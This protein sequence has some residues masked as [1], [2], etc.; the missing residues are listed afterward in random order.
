M[1]ENL[2]YVVIDSEN[3]LRGHIAHPDRP[4]VINVK[5]KGEVGLQAARWMCSLDV[6]SDLFWSSDAMAV[7]HPRE[8]DLATDPSDGGAP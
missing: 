6:T 1:A 4:G 5:W 8:I 7:M 2:D 3:P